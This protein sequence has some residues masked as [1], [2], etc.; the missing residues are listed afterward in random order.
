M[1]HCA[2]LAAPDISVM[3]WKKMALLR[4]SVQHEVFDLMV[5]GRRPPNQERWRR[6]VIYICKVVVRESV[7][8]KMKNHA[9][10]CLVERRMSSSTTFA[11]AGSVFSIQCP[12]ANTATAE[13][14]S[15]QT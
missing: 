4:R 7:P 3:T 13:D 10:A 9:E 5:Q 2:T 6:H 11:N 1:S 8:R 12:A 14:R 15:T